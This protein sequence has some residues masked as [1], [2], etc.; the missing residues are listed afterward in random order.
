MQCNIDKT[1]IR[2]QMKEKRKLLEKIEIESK[3]RA[4][5]T[6]FAAMRAFR[7]AN[8]V[9]VYMSAFGEVETSY[10]VDRC[11]QMNKTVVVPVV[12]GDNI[13]L[14]HF[15]GITEK[16][17]YGIRVPVSKSVFPAED[18]DIFAVPAL[19]FDRRG[20]RVGFGKGYYDKLLKNTH[21]VK[22]G[23]CYDFQMLDNI[24]AQEHDIFMDYVITESEMLSC[25]KDF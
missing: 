4:I 24:P 2:G 23:L 7:D 5:C 13:Y 9:S 12:D 10:I 21:G 1:S 25:R 8:T 18:V 17:T 6:A 3:S 11:K 14:C 22:V 19:A 20:G 16:G 15:T